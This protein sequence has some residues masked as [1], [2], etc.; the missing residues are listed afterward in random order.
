MTQL[1]NGKSANVDNRNK[2]HCSWNCETQY[3]ITWLGQ[4]K[5]SSPAA[6][7]QGALS[8]EGKMLPNFK[9]CCCHMASPVKF[10]SPGT[11][12]LKR[13][14]QILAWSSQCYWLSRESRNL[15]SRRRLW[16]RTWRAGASNLQS[17]PGGSLVLTGWREPRSQEV[18]VKQ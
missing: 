7:C 16:C 5:P 13:E 1:T 17:A 3:H 11:S 4:T 14:H 2:G 18:F 10:P 8:Q 6:N 12:A 9:A 15:F